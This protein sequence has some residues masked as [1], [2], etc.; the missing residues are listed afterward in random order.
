MDELLDSLNV[1]ITRNTDDTSTIEI[2]IKTAGDGQEMPVIRFTNSTLLKDALKA[3]GIT[4]TTI[5]NQP[6]TAASLPAA[7]TSA[8]LADLLRRMTACH[9]LPTA[10]RVN[11]QAGT[12]SDVTGQECRSI[13]RNN[14]PAAYLHFRCESRRQGRV[15]DAVFRKRHRR[16]LWPHYTTS[17][18]RL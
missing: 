16:R 13:F 8:Q 9:A 10:T 7:G 2:T 12:A 11:N 3:N 4:A 6:I 14:N 17:R 1:S 18:T 5:Q 15:P